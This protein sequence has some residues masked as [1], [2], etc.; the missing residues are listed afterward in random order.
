MSSEQITELHLQVE[1]TYLDSNLKSYLIG[2][3]A[4][5]GM[6]KFGEPSVFH[7]NFWER[8]N[9]CVSGIT[10]CKLMACRK[11]EHAYADY[12]RSFRR[13]T[14]RIQNA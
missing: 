3:P 2:T 1:F 9:N 8:Q 11:G 4:G 7:V 14:E 5:I 12:I 10:M 13:T 6:P